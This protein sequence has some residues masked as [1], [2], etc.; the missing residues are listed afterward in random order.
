MAE[1]LTRPEVDEAEAEANSQEA[2]ANS[3][4]AKANS[5]EAEAQAKIALIVFSQILHFDPIVSK[6]EI[7][8]RFS[9]KLQNFWLK[10]G[11]NMGLY[12]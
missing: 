5:H 2:E 1:M 10:T 12:Q 6:S 9:T 8:G 11:F 7:L 4:E 3:H